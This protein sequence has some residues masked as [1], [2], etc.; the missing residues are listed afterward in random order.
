MF[1]ILCIINDILIMYYF[2]HSFQNLLIIKERK[3][4]VC[5]NFVYVL[6]GISPASDCV[7]PTFRNAL[8]GPYSK[9][10]CEV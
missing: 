9:A 7:L 6:L 10:G 5:R 4:E 8:S 2:S 3:S 1:S